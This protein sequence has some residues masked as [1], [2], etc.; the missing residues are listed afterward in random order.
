M[1]QPGYHRAFFMPFYQHSVLI[2]L[3][4]NKILQNTRLIYLNN[5]LNCISEKRKLYRI[6]KEA[7][8]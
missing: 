8:Q 7:Q 6:K 1:I 5:N 2:I 3:I 4:K